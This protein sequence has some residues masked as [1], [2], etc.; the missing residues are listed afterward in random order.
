MLRP[1]LAC[2]N[3]LNQSKKDLIK[4]GLNGQPTGII[5][6]NF[7]EMVVKSQLGQLEVLDL[8]WCLEDYV[9]IREAPDLLKDLLGGSSQNAVNSKWIIGLKWVHIKSFGQ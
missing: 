1:W 7:S 5:S 6:Y 3:D 2:P 8:V 9:N 4:S